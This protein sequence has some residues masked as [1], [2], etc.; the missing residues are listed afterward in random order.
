MR[1]ALTTSRPPLSQIGVLAFEP[2]VDLL[3]RLRKAPKSPFLRI[4][5][6]LRKM[7]DVCQLHLTERVFRTAKLSELEKLGRLLL[8]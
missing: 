1:E 6:A 8:D 7:T 5:R 2:G 4:L 3:E